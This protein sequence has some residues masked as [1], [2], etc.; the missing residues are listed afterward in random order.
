MSL[1]EGVGQCEFFPCVPDPFLIGVKGFPVVPTWDDLA[2]GGGLFIQHM[3]GR[4]TDEWH[5]Y[6]ILLFILL[7]YEPEGIKLH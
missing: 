5:K 6:R 1:K 3:E 7:I 4:A 2:K